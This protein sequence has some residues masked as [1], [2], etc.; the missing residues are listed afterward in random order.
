MAY[1]AEVVTEH[2]ATGVSAPGRVRGGATRVDAPDR[3]RG[4]GH[5]HDDD[6]DRSCNNSGDGEIVV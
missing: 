3:V 2:G 4:L 5:G 6:N 1:V